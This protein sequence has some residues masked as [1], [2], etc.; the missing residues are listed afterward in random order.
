MIESNLESAPP[1]GGFAGLKENWR[2]DALAGFQIFLIA[3]PLCLGIAMASNFP[4]M[5]GVTTAIVGGLLVSRINGSYVTISGPAAG[6]IVVTLAAVQ[7]LGAGDAMLGYRLALAAVVC[8]GALQALL[9]LLR[10][11]KLSALFP[12][13]VVHGML[14]AIGVIIMAKQIHTVLGVKPEAREIFDTIAEIPHSVFNLNPE[15]ALIGTV[16]LSLMILWPRIRLRALRLFPAPIVVVLIGMALGQWFDL[17]HQHK[18]LLHFPEDHTYSVGPEFLVAIP[19]NFLDGF[20][21]PDFS[22]FATPQFW[23]IVLTICLVSSIESMLSAAAIDKLD[24]FQRQSNLN[25]DLT[26]LGIGTSVAG[27]LG[28]LPMISEI[29]RSSANIDNGA[30]TGWSNFFH[31]FFMLSF[32]ALFPRLIHEIPLASL[33]ALLVYTGYRLASPKEFAKTLNIGVEQLALFMLTIIAVLATD[34]LIGVA[35]GIVAKIT[36]HL[37]RGV[38][39]KTLF[40]TF[41]E[42]ERVEPDSYHVK[43]KGSVIFSN[44]IALNS[45]LSEL[46]PRK[47]LRFDLADADFIDHTVMEFIHDFCKDYNR[48]GGVCEISGLDQHKAFSDHPLAAR[49]REEKVPLW[50]TLNQNF[51]SVTET[52]EGRYVI[53]VNTLRIIAKLSQQLQEKTEALPERKIVV[54]DYSDAYFLDRSAMNYINEF[55]DQY[56]KNGGICQIRGLTGPYWPDGSDPKARAPFSKYPENSC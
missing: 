23:G 13:S 40:R 49:K 55:S 46:E 5:A 39:L 10:V 20:Y 43:V 4:P 16:S 24:P 33:A 19:M 27:F 6:L 45:A 50:E 14:A 37:I 56:Q 3:L 1:S 42:I 32:V 53:K 41:Y 17:D 7:T 51:Y 48:R 15:I 18:Y 25:K 31:G 22:R 30:R 12:S 8:A 36:I 2:Y 38:S 35:I 29:I 28:G 52:E 44:F 26:G 21:F 47:K 54:F 9:G 11:G 34:L